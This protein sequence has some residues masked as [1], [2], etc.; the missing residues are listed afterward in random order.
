MKLKN[1][2]NPSVMNILDCLTCIPT[3]LTENMIVGISNIKLYRHI[4]FGIKPAIQQT[5]EIII[6]VVNILYQP[7]IFKN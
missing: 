7:Q 4:P 6:N 2:N 5:N 1:K 3:F